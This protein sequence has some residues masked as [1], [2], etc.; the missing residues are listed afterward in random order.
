[1]TPLAIVGEAKMS[2]QIAF[3]YLMRNEPEKIGETVPRHEEY[4]QTR[5]LR[6]YRGGPFGDLSGGLITFEAE[7]LEQAGKIVQGDPF[8]A[9]ALLESSWLKEWRVH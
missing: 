7:D 4:W 8:V 5:E 1:V 3:F 9:E 6:E 2:T